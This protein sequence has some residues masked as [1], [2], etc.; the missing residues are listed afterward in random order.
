[1]RWFSYRRKKKRSKDNVVIRALTDWM[2]GKAS[3]KGDK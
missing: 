1:M 3:G 2:V